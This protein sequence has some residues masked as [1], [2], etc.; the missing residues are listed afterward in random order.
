MKS[1]L[2][3]AVRLLSPGLF[4]V[5]G[6][7]VASAIIIALLPV[8]PHDGL[9]LWLG[10]GNHANLYRALAPEWNRR[11]PDLPLTV[12]LIAGPALQSRMLSGFYS[13]TPLPDLIEVERNQIGQV[14]AGPLSDVGF[15]DLTD[16]LARDGLLNEITPASFSPWSTR[17]RIFGLPRGAHPVVLAYRSDLVEAAGI[18]VSQ[19]ETWDDYFRLMRPLLKDL[20]GDGYIDRYPLTI[21]LTNASFSEIFL[22]QAGGGYFD[23][24]GN[25]QLNSATNVQVVARLATWYAGPGRMVGDINMYTGAGLRLLGQGYAVAIPSADWF[26]GNLPVSLPSLT[27]KIKVM[28]LPAWAK[29]GRHTSVN[30][31]T[32]I[33]VTKASKHPEVAWELVKFLY[34]SPVIARQLYDL[35]HIVSPVKSTWSAAYLDRPDPYFGG[36]PVGRILQQAVPDIPPR[37]ASPYLSSAVQLVNSVISQLMILTDSKG[38]ERPEQV[39]ADAQRLLDEAQHTLLAQIHRNVFLATPA[40]VTP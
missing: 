30:G 4:V 37:Y 23:A 22:L 25:P 6:L 12:T 14:F 35:T 17:G 19:I 33:G 18:D 36:Q 8:P 1:Y 39:T 5:L 7:G 15:A 16:R 40:P 9:Q 27:G 3:A 38:Y 32:M 28:P 34:F 11:H 10:D 24:S 20:D 31:G 29:G 13:G 21:S 2:T 26:V